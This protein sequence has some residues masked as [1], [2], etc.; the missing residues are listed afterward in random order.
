MWFLY[1]FTPATMPSW[2]I[3]RHIYISLDRPTL[4][5]WQTSQAKAK[6]H[7][8]IIKAV[9]DHDPPKL[10]C[11]AS[12]AGIGTSCQQCAPTS[13]GLLP[14]Y[15]HPSIEIIWPWSGAKQ[16]WP[17]MVHR[18]TDCPSDWFRHARYYLYF[19][20]NCFIMNASSHNPNLQRLGTLSF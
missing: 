1:K 6:A 13:N 9:Y 18:M 16:V 5:L 4:S 17:K 7:Q 20:K 10:T 15:L 8:V 3:K 19:L 2:P 11:G 12:H 14:S